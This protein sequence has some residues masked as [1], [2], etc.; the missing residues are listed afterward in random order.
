MPRTFHLEI[1]EFLHDRPY[2]PIEEPV[3]VVANFTAL[4]T[5]WADHQ[6]RGLCV[7]LPRSPSRRAVM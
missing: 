3:S 4:V 5:Y 2:D 7:T 6:D 1:G